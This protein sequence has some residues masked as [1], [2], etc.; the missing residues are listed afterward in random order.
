MI[1]T[2]EA[3]PS[4]AAAMALE[5]RLE[6]A[7]GPL[8]Y[9]G[10]RVLIATR[11]KPRGTFRIA[12][13]GD[14]MS[15]GAG[16]LYRKAFSAR[17][18]AH[19]ND[20]VPGTWVEAV[21]FGVSGA[22]IHHAAGRA[23]THALPADADLVVIA[24]CCNDAFLL[25]P[26]PADL[27]VLGHQWVTFTP[28]VH[29]SLRAF[30]DAVTAQGRQPMV[31]YLDKLLQAGEICVPKALG[32][33]CA[34]LGIPFVDGSSVLTAYRQSDLM[35]STA[36]GHL[37]G[38][39]YDVIAR[40]ATQAIVGLG[41]LPKSPGFDD[42]S[43]LDAIEGGARERVDAGLPG[44]LA[45]GE[46]L[47]VLAGKWGNRRNTQRRQHQPR[48]AAA[49]ERLLASHRASLAHLA[50]D[51]FQEGLRIR[52]PLAGLWQVEM[53]AN[54]LMAL[55]FAFE[56]WLQAGGSDGVLAGLDH[57]SEQAEEPLSVPASIG[58]WEQIRTAVGGLQRTLDKALALTGPLRT[59]PRLDYLTLW[60]SRVSQWLVTVDRCAE[61]YLDLL[62]RVVPPLDA[63]GAL[64][65][66]YSSRRTPA[67]NAKLGALQALAGE[68]DAAGR[69]AARAAGA[70][71]AALDL[72]MSAAP[73][74]ESWTFTVGMETSTPAFSERHVGTGYF[75]RDGEPHVYEL[76]LPVALSGHIHVYIQG[77]GLK[78]QSGSIRV[79]KAV[80]RWPLEGIEPVT[81]PQPVLESS[82]EISAAIVFRAGSTLPKIPAPAAAQP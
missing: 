27:A 42:A 6:C 73:G 35:V 79:R 58:R 17:L 77:E 30:N 57:L 65:L 20:A 5:S 19:L 70:P 72:V 54:E 44:A 4:G 49:R 59:S 43:W 10:N 68:L 63:H 71:F 7:E 80:V 37:S 47:S 67:L 16:V 60:S 53:F 8:T 39:A 78:T 32:S 13:I 50:Y 33:I 22:C 41:V 75:I 61:R 12:V 36:D 82:T 9:A 26:Q 52:H 2:D 14:S 28:L 11:T 18:A 1:V 25:G 38:L 62:A 24:V 66:T 40:H 56:H 55:S 34:E 74:P 29:R 81:L 23:I 15:Y 48:Y 45:F 46:A 31:V 76:D 69:G 51:S 3:A 64:L 21:S